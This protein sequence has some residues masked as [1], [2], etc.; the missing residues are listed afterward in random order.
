MGRSSQRWV[1]AGAAV[2]V[3]VNKLVSRV[4]ADVTEPTGLLDV[5]AGDEAQEGMTAFLEK[6]KPEWKNR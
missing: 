5:R 6:R 2:G 4:A 3:A 1:E